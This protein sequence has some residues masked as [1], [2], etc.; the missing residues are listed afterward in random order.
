VVTDR[1]LTLR[2]AL[3]IIVYESSRILN[4]CSQAVEEGGDGTA[5]EL[6]A[7]VTRDAMVGLAEVA[8]P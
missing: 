1:V 5:E 7:L 3:V 8:E 2:D 4:D 6:A